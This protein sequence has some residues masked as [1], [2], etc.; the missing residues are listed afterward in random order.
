MK[1]KTGDRVYVSIYYYLTIGF[2]GIHKTIWNK[3]RTKFYSLRLW[4]AIWHRQ[5]WIKRSLSLCSPG[6]AS[7]PTN[8]ARLVFLAIFHSTALHQIFCSSHRVFGRFLCLRIKKKKKKVLHIL[9]FTL[10]DQEKLWNV[11]GIKDIQLRTV[12]WWSIFH[13]LAFT[14][15][16]IIEVSTWLCEQPGGYEDTVPYPRGLSSIPGNDQFLV[17]VSLGQTVIKGN[18]MKHTFY[19]LY[20][21]FWV[22]LL[23][24]MGKCS[25]QFIREKDYSGIGLPAVMLVASF[26]PLHGTVAACLRTCF[27]KQALET[28]SASMYEGKWGGGCVCERETER[29]RERQL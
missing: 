22:N 2:A 4:C 18:E 27:W 28:K 24:I 5:M 9:F 14:L 11:Y 20:P 10:T 6:K 1:D 16:A 7:P 29:E 23:G 12:N 15:W 25:Q 13:V 26:G 19:L 17:G 21:E 8:T 3:P